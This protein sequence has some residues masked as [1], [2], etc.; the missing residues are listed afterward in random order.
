ME[1][2]R[3][4][5]ENLVKRGSG[6]GGPEAGNGEEDGR[7]EEGEGVFKLNRS[8]RTD[9]ALNWPVRFMLDRFGFFSQLLLGP[10]L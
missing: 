6:N 10:V 9:F 1:R 8:K 4:G 2:V 3:E 7:E 5:A